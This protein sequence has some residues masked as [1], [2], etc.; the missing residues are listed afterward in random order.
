[1]ALL[2]IRVTDTDALSYATQPVRSIL[3]KAETAKK[4]KYG[5]ACETRRAS[6]TPFVV[7]VDGCLGREAKA[8]LNRLCDNLAH[9]WNRSYSETTVWIRTRLAFSIVRASSHCIRG[10]RTKWRGCD[11]DD[12]AFMQ[13]ALA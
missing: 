6:F 9:K 13:T 2:D 11:V 1:M 4:A 10:T 5:A 3:A 8:F 12:G 7:S